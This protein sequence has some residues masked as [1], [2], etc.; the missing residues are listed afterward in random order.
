MRLCAHVFA[1]KREREIREG[2]HYN[3]EK[4]VTTDHIG[5]KQLI[6]ALMT[7]SLVV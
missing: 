2:Y 1:L 4:N 7:I 6:R 3:E 5:I